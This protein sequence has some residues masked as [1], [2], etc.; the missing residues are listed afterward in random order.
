MTGTGIRPGY[1]VTNLNDVSEED[2]SVEFSTVERFVSK[3]RRV[4]WIEPFDA[5][6]FVLE[7]TSKATSPVEFSITETLNDKLKRVCWLT[8]DVSF[9]HKSKLSAS[10]MF[11]NI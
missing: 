11:R 6:S 2:S 5:L 7:G 4:C 8:L 1:Q 3:E 9:S 10:V